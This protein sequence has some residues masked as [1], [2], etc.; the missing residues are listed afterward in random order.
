VKEWP[1]DYQAV[2]KAAAMPLSN[3]ALAE[4]ALPS[5]SSRIPLENGKDSLG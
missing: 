1:E 2:F 4:S 5:D 3:P